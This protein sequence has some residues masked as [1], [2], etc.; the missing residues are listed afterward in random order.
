MKGLD[1]GHKIP[2]VEG[3]LNY[4]NISLC[5]IL[6]KDAPVKTMKCFIKIQQQ[7]YTENTANL[8]RTRKGH[9]RI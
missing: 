5:D 8:I 7:W 6:S 4:F 1:D 2:D 3:M 9:E